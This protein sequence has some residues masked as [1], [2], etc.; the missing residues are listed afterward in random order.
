MNVFSDCFMI[1]YISVKKS[2]VEMAVVL[3]LTLFWIQLV[4]RFEVHDLM[5]T[6]FIFIHQAV[7]SKYLDILYFL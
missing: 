3:G 4:I 1:G 7:Y 2:V 5:Q 6:F